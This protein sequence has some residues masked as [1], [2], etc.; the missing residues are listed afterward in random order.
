MQR[1]LLLL[2]METRDA[3]GL[4]LRPLVGKRVSDRKPGAHP[5][6]QVRVGPDA[7]QV[8]HHVHVAIASGHMKSRL[9]RLQEQDGKQ[10][11]MTLAAFIQMALCT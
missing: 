6:G 9:P 1:G 4:N 8:V 5:V 3:K 10:K 11:I 2:E 7:A